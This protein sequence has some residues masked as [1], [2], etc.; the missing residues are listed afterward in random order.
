MG[1][2]PGNNGRDGDAFV[3]EIQ[4][5]LVALPIIMVARVVDRRDSHP[6]FAV[7]Q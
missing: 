3:G 6:G 1:I 4:V 5:Q 2:G 7:S